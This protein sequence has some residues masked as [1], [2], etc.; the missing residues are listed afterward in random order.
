[1]YE[2]HIESDEFK[3]KRTVQQHQLVNQVTITSTPVS[4]NGQSIVSHNL[5]MK[6]NC[7]SLS[8][9]INV[10]YR[11]LHPYPCRLLCFVCSGVWP[12]LHPLIHID[13]TSNDLPTNIVTTE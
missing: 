12:V 9:I 2:I 8:K 4:R 6:H 11:L 5:K 3:G 1:M 10:S 7:L 13:I